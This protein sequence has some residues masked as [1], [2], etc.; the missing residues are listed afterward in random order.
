MKRITV[1]LPDELEQRLDTYRKAQLVT[2]SLTKVVQKAL[3]SFLDNWTR[4]ELEKRG[5]EPLSRWPVNFPVFEKG[6]GKRDISINHDKYLAE[7]AKD[8]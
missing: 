6:S 3:E 5:Y 4:Q 1:T 7:A 8:T 2:P